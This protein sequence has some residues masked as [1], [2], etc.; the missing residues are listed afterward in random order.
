MRS[1]KFSY[2]ISVP[3]RERAIRK[4]ANP[5]SYNLTSEQHIEYITSKKSSSKQP[6]KQASKYPGNKH[7]KGRGKPGKK[8][9]QSI[10]KSAKPIMVTQM[11]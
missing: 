8:E 5:P 10:A 6:A 4:R 7:P 2:L 1:V 3:H 11:T 9:K